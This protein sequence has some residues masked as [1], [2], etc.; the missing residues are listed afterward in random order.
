[1]L[2][3][4]KISMAVNDND[5]LISTVSTGSVSAVEILLNTGKYDINYVNEYGDTPLTT[6][7]NRNDDEMVKVLIVHGAIVNEQDYILLKK[8]AEEHKNDRLLLNVPTVTNFLL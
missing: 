5:I 3:M 1:M 2:T 6:A 8:C 4:A 7:A